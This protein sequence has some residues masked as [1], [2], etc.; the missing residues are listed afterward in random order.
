MPGTLP[1]PRPRKRQHHG[2]MAQQIDALD[3][4]LTEAGAR[5]E[6]L[7]SRLEAAERENAGF[8]T[9]IAQVAKVAD[10]SNAKADFLAAALIAAAPGA[11]VDAAGRPSARH[12]ETLA[13]ELPEADEEWLAGVTADLWPADEYDS[14]DGPGETP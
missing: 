11:M 4:G 12:P 7:V 9:L 10:N 8:V 3:R 14:S 6:F 1:S 5:I 2:T 13:G